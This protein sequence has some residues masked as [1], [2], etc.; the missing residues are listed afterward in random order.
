MA[1]KRGN[2][3]YGKTEVIRQNFDKFSP[4]FWQ[5]M[6][7]M[8]KSKNRDDRRLF[9]QEFNKIQ[10]KMIPQ[11]LTGEGGGDIK[12]QIVQY[13]SNPPVQVHAEDI[14]TTLTRSL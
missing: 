10:T 1:N 5:L 4:V 13:G 12:V 3:G 6:G 14:S 7:E 2:Q 8:A 11:E 9:I